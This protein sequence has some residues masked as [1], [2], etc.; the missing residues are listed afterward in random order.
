MYV[1]VTSGVFFQQVFG[2]GSCNIHIAGIELHH[3]LVGIGVYHHNIPQRLVVQ[4]FAEFKI[5]VVV[6]ESHATGFAEL[7]ALVKNLHKPY[8]VVVGLPQTGIEPGAYHIFLS[9]I[10]GIVNQFFPVIGKVVKVFVPMLLTKNGVPRWHFHTQVVQYFFELL[11]S[12]AIKS[13]VNIVGMFNIF[14]TDLGQFG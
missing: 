5:V 8:Q 10:G 9:H 12:P 11:G 1:V 14:I 7:S 13:L 2:K 3:H 6:T 4:F